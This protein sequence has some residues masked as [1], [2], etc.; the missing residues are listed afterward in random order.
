MQCFSSHIV[1]LPPTHLFFLRERFI[2]LPCSWLFCIT[3]LQKKLLLWHKTDCVVVGLWPGRGGGGGIVPTSGSV[4]VYKRRLMILTLQQLM[5][6]AN[7]PKQ[8]ISSFT[9][10]FVWYR[11]LGLDTTYN[12]NVGA[13]N[14][15]PFQIEWFSL[16]CETL[17][18]SEMSMW[19]S[20][21]IAI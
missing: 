10:Q 7:S 2:S 11:C 15:C 5:Q 14:L 13:I 20:Q 21:W 9:V 16:T 18:T 8:R 12:G 6:T 3:D 1:S 4:S 17:S 19:P